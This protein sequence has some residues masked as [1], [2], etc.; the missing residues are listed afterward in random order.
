MLR[1]LKRESN[2]WKST[3]QRVNELSI[4]ESYF[5]AKGLAL[6]NTSYIKTPKYNGRILWEKGSSKVY[7][8]FGK[9][10]KNHKPIL[11]I[12]SLINKPY[13]L[14]ISKSKSFMLRLVKLG[15]SPYLLDWGE[16]SA[17]EREYTLDDYI[18]ERLVSAINYI[19]CL[20]DGNSLT[21]CGYCMGGFF[22]IAGSILKRELVDRVITIATPWDFHVLEFPKVNYQVFSKYLDGFKYTVPGWFVSNMFYIQNIF[23]INRKFIN[24]ARGYYDNKE[25]IM[26]ENWVNDNVNIAKPVL[27]ECLYNLMERNDLYNGRWLVGGEEIK[28]ASMNVPSLCVIAKNDALSPYNSALALHKQLRRSTLVEMGSGHIG[29][30]LNKKYGLAEKIADWMNEEIK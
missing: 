3:W 10:N 9:R 20:E 14:D 8:Y 1:S 6:Y 23:D 17:Q 22:A 2:F 11:L 24:F 18:N 16:P 25:F 30:I 29:M 4:N 28:A 5:L 21:L 7:K 12:P 26:I 19:S 13:I 15:L 27:V